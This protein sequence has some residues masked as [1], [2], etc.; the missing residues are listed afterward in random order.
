MSARLVAVL[1]AV[2]AVAC[3]NSSP[4]GA[5]ECAD[6]GG[7]CNIGMCRGTAGPQVCDPGLD[8]GGA[9]CCLPCPSGMM[10]SDGGGITGC[11]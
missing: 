4:N 2:G 5:A 9:F 10:P 6:A 8:P 7:T 11:H 3:S 1:L